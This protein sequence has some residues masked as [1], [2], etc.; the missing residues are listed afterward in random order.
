MSQR[1]LEG[2][3]EGYRERDTNTAY[4]LKQELER[5]QLGISNLKEGSE[6]VTRLEQEVV[7]LGETI[8]Q[9]NSVLAVY[10]QKIETEVLQK[11]ATMHA[12]SSR[13]NPPIT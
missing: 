9:N 13:K 6:R 7:S 1:K 3:V 4:L 2:I 10:L 8:E 11:W 5:L 12:V